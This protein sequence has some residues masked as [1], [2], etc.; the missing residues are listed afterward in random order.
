MAVSRTSP[1]V[2]TSLTK[3]IGPSKLRLPDRKQGASPM[4]TVDFIT[5]LFCRVDDRMC[6]VAKH[7]QALSFDCCIL[8]SA[9][10]SGV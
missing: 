1:Q 5:T 4:T 10:E 2:E 3:A 6:G 7:A 8:I 9:S